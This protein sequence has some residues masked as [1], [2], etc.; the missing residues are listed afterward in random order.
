[1]P[2][3]VFAPSHSALD[4]IFT[5]GAT[6]VIPAYQRPY[7][8]QALGKSDSNNQVNQMWD[9]LWAFFEENQATDKEYF[10]GSMVIIE[11]KLRSFE[12]IDGQQRLTTIALLFAAMRCFLAS[13]S[14][15]AAPE[16]ADF[17][18]RAD[19]RLDELLFNREG[20]GLVQSA[21]LKIERATGYDFDKALND[22]I[23]CS[24]QTSV[25]DP[26]NREIAERYFKNRDYFIERLRQKFVTSG[27][28]TAEDAN[29]FN[30]FFSFLNARVSLVLI[31][32]TDFE[33]AYFIF[34]TLNNRGLPLSGR[35][36]LRNFLIKELSEAGQDDPAS[37]WV[38]LENE[39]SLTEDFMGR[40]VEST[41]AAQSRAS[42]FT[43]MVEIY[44][45]SYHDLPGRPRIQQFCSVLRQDLERYSMIVEC[46]QRIASI[47]IRNKLRFLQGLGNDRYTKNLLL[48]LFRHCDYRGDEDEDV[49]DVLCALQRWILHIILTP[50]VRF[51]NANIYAAIRA[52]KEGKLDGAKAAIAL[53]DEQKSRLVELIGGNIDNVTAKFLL[54]AY[55]WHQEAMHEDVVTQRLDLDKATL[56]HIIPQEPG[57]DTNWR[58]DFSDEFRKQYTYRLGNMTLLTMKMNSAARNFDFTAKQVHYKKT[59]LPITRTLAELNAITP[60]TIEARHKDVVAGVLAELRL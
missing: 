29:R 31:S 45:S 7:S 46:E 13:M 42:A 9:D 52:L 58:R 22:A 14:A 49:L 25:P 8:W 48:A 57:K 43:G 27:Q 50:G 20:V 18:K 5:S 11:K 59:L 37:V 39:F 6:Y 53:T 60:A 16:L 21:K 56:E 41:K 2:R 40:W 44:H 36:L 3:T 30:Q 34:E 38:A 26:K 32:T 33:T 12:V 19:A 51:S 15:T 55:V 17:L 4:G 24:P 28:F 1:M 35:D 10:L 54:A 47:S 23:A